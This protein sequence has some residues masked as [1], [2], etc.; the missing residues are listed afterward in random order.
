[1]TY[2][3]YVK[4]NFI[5]NPQSDGE[6]DVF[7][8]VCCMKTLKKQMFLSG[9]MKKRHMAV[10]LSLIL[11]FAVFTNI[12]FS[13]HNYRADDQQL[14]NTLLTLRYHGEKHSYTLD[15]LKD[16]ESYSGTG[17]RLN[18]INEVTGPLEYTGVRI[19][20]LI[21][22]IPGVH[23]IVDLMVI[24]SDGYVTKFT[25]NQI[26]GQVTIYDIH[27]EKTGVGGVIMMLAYEE[28][29]VSDFSGGPLRIAWVNNGNPITDSFLWIKYVQEID[30]IDNVT[31]DHLAPTLTLTQP[32]NGLYFMNHRI[33]PLPVPLIFGS[34]MVH[35]STTDES[36]GVMNVLFIVD[37]T[38]KEIKDIFPFQWTWDE[39]IKGSHTLK[40][41]AYDFAGNIATKEQK[42]MIYNR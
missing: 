14:E 15:D 39:N 37:E 42:V 17:G 16:L 40:I 21:E 9:N 38:L 33:F 25:N 3:T 19:S 4:A 2:E 30:I 32:V 27:G 12:C 6:A 20:T 34:I 13:Y 11:S 18:S 5:C 31:S 29:G 36:S 22:D 1:M 28:E 24:S 35:V 26:N 41:I 8:I 10:F 23:P 7:D